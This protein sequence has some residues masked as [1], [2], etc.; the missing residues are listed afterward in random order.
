MD[1]FLL[2]K[3]LF[4]FWKYLKNLQVYVLVLDFPK[5]TVLYNIQSNL[6]LILLFH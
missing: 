1:N 4:F 5:E 2:S 6:M 3:I